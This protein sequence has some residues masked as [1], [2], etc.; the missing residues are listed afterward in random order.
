[1]VARVVH[2]KRTH[3]DDIFRSDAYMRSVRSVRKY[4]R[5]IARYPLYPQ[6]MAIIIL[7]G[8]LAWTANYSGGVGLLGAVLGIGYLGQYLIGVVQETTLGHAHPP[9]IVD[10]IVTQPGYLRLALLLVYLGT[11]V[12]AANA[13][14][15]LGIPLLAYL[16]LG[17]GTAMLPAFIAVL[18]VVDDMRE[19]GNPLRLRHFIFNTERGYYA[20]GIP[21]I[22]M[23]WVA[24]ALHGGL[25]SLFCLFAAS[26]LLVALS[27][28][29]GF[30]ACHRYAELNTDSE[31]LKQGD[32]T[33]RRNVQQEALDALLSEIDGLVARG[34]P[35]TAC[36]IMFRE[37]AGLTNPLQF[38]QDLYHA[39][40]VRRQ[41]VLMLVQGKRLIHMLMQVKHIG[42]ALSIYEECLDISPYFR[43][44][45]MRGVLQLAESALQ[46]HRLR[47]FD[48]IVTSV[49]LRNP[50]GPETAALQF[51][52]ARYLAEVEKN[53][54][55][56]LDELRPLVTLVSHPLHSRIAALYRALQNKAA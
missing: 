8:V 30:V 27:H 44:W 26:Y 48:K 20:L 15:W 10:E 32:T 22:V 51:R 50:G 47:C 18:S 14:Q 52:K 9:G 13:A 19:A 11:F 33:R 16:A 1:M 21:M 55:A 23:V 12:A 37:H 34:D 38:H 40:K 24:Y 43:P 36:D 45:D 46:D 29:L 7:L 5:E 28:L 31:I 2:S 4:W 39:L 54:A 56:A 49:V 35:R 41:Y 25:T 17:I 53:E 42:R 6:A 3:E